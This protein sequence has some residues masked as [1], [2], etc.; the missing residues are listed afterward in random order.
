M[1]MSK[2]GS[3]QIMGRQNGNEECVQKATMD[4]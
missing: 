4:G 2:T 1:I 3:E